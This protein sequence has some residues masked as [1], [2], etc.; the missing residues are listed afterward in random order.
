[1]NDDASISTPMT[2]GRVNV[3]MDSVDLDNGCNGD[4]N[5]NNI[6]Y[7]LNE[8]KWRIKEKFF[9]RLPTITTIPVF[10]PN[11]LSE[12]QDKLKSFLRISFSLDH[13]IRQEREQRPVKCKTE[14]DEQYE[15]RLEIYQSRD[16]A[17]YLILDRSINMASGLDVKYTSLSDKLNTDGIESIGQTLYDGILKLLKGSHLYARLE[18]LNNIMDIKLQK[19]G[20]EQDVFNQ[21][22]RQVDVQASFQLDLFKFQRLLLINSL[23]ISQHQTVS[24]QLAAMTPEELFKLTPQD[25]LDRYLASAG[26]LLGSGKDSGTAVALFTE[27]Q[28]GKKKDS[29]ER[30]C[31]HCGKPGHYKSNCPSLGQVAKKRKFTSTKKKNN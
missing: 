13:L 25:I 24:L 31:Y 14:S 17:L 11:S 1:M 27:S 26:H 18:S 22:K 7:L 16:R 30:L 15:S 5:N 9:D 21:W 20:S 8:S 2:L 10:T 3:L 19:V 23:S 28:E 6:N 29:S 4:F 12:Y